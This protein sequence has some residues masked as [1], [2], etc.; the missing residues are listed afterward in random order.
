[1]DNITPIQQMNE[2]ARATAEKAVNSESFSFLD[3]LQG[4]EYPTESVEIFVNERAA[5]E[6]AALEKK[7]ALIKDGEDANEIQEKIDA[8]R[9]K[10]ASSRFIVHLEGIPVDQYDAVVDLAA[11]EYPYEY[12]ESRNPLTFAIERTVIDSP[13]REQ[14]FRTHLWAK[15]ITS[16]ESPTGATDNNITPDWVGYF[17]AKAP[18]I[19][20]LRVARAIEKLRM[21]SDWMEGLLTE[22]F[23]P[24]A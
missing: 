13:M 7:L 10:A 14:F 3:V 18:V 6:L 9:E 8:L 16:V 17:I 2:E 21:T 15:Y 12:T 22:D 20:Q 23:F 5:Y 1:M 24:S 11:A 4:R 19:A